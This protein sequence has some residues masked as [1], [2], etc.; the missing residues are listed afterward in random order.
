[1]ATTLIDTHALLWWLTGSQRLPK[2]ARQ[3]IA[4]AHQ[5]SLVS[6]ASA[7]EISIKMALG[8]LHAPGD[9]VAVVEASGL[10][11]VPVEPA[12]AYEAGRLPIHHRDPF[13]RLLVA[14]ATLRS[15]T[16]VSGDEVFDSYGVSR[17]WS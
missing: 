4:D 5:V 8:K 14:Q 16:L 1:M 3:R 15:A 13:D 7:W 2:K 10:L 17:L 12:E 11:W 9:L 6:A